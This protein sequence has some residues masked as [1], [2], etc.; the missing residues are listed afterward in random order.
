MGSF[1][2]IRRG[3]PGGDCTGLYGPGRREG[4]E[5][6]PF[7]L[8]LAGIKLG[9][10]CIGLYSVASDLQGSG[11]LCLCD[12]SFHILNLLEMRILHHMPQS[13]EV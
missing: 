7:L 3:L 8:A 13:R 6:F 5:E 2:S 4:A 10:T 11:K 1:V 9:H 12:S